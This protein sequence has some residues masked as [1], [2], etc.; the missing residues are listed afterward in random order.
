M[1]AAPPT[2][3]ILAEMDPLAD[4]YATVE[5]RS[6]P[7]LVSNTSPHIAWGAPRSSNQKYCAW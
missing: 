3:E 6:A 5:R 7:G 4:E 1:R 2:S